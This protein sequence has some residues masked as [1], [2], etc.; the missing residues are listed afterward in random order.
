MALPQP[1][2]LVRRSIARKKVQPPKNKQARF[3]ALPAELFAELQQLVGD[4]PESVL[5]RPERT[6]LSVVAACAGCRSSDE[7]AAPVIAGEAK[8]FRNNASGNF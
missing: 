1:G 4:D 7:L 6:P 2:L 5:F 8:R 3:Q